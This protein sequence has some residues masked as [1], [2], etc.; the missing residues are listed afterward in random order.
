MPKPYVTQRPYIMA[1]ETGSVYALTSEEAERLIAAYT[2]LHAQ[3]N[4]IS[5]RANDGTR[6]IIAPATLGGGRA[7]LTGRA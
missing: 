2:V 7:F 6:F 5:M 3:P 4:R 1:V